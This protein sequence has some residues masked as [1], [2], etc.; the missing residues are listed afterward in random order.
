MPP[1][2]G[3]KSVFGHTLGAAGALDA[4]FSVLALRDGILPPTVAHDKPIAAWDFVP[5]G[6]RAAARPLRTALSTNSAFGGNN[7]ALI[8]RRWESVRDSGSRGSGDAA[9]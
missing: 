7:S 8:L 6:A 2:S 4:V 9:P 5:G 3:V 1:I